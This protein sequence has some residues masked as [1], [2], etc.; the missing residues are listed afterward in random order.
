M[1]ISPLIVIPARY[2][3]LAGLLGAVMIVVLFYAGRHPFLIPPFLDFRVL[4]FAVLIFFALREYREYA[5]SGVL[6]FWQ[7][8]LGSYAFIGAFALVGTSAVIITGLAEPDFVGQY[9]T[10][11]TNLMVQSK[12]NIVEAVGPEAYEIQLRNLPGTTVYTLAA[13]YFLK[14]LLIGLFLSVIISVIA[15]RIPTT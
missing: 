13:D 3:L 4:L 2:G 5:N 10:A 9:V 6:Y 12:A 11:M 8:V 1:K 7:G 14:S 15:R